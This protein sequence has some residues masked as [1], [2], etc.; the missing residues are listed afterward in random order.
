VEPSFRDQLLEKLLAEELKLANKHLPKHRKSLA[1]LLTEEDPHVLCLDGTFH[2]FRRS[3]LRTL[4][5]LLPKNQWNELKL[6]IIIEVGETLSR[7]VAGV[8]RDSIAAKII[9]KLLN[10]PYKE[11]EILILY[12]PQLAELRAKLETTTQYAFIAPTEIY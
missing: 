11:R 1:E 3:E 10:I 7:D 8:I 6:P 12:R 4:A 9:A 2:Y 5:R